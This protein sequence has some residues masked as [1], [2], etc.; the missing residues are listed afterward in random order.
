MWIPVIG[1]PP[2]NYTDYMT[3]KQARG[4]AIMIKKFVIQIRLVMVTIRTKWSTIW[5]VL[6]QV[7][8]KL[9]NRE[10]KSA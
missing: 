2:D 8:T 5:S 10:W 3:I 4:E 6:I 7:I 1:H 9:D